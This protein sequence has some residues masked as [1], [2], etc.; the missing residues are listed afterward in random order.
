[1][2]QNVESPTTNDDRE[3]K[4]AIIRLALDEIAIDIDVALRD[5]HLDFPVYL[6]VPHSGE[7]LATLACPVDPSDEEWSKAATI[8][9][10]VVSERLGD[11]RLCG[12]PLPC[13]VANS[14]MGD[15]DIINTPASNTPS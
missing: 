14:T 2:P 1:M 11:V 3:E 5:A 4:R 7:A 9:C 10:L 15:T 12:R 8:A 13:A 6:T